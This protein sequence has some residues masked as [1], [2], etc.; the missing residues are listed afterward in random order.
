[1]DETEEVVA[2]EVTEEEAPETMS[3]E[4]VA[5]AEKDSSDEVAAE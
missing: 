2:P 3:D 5:D 1:M 4:S